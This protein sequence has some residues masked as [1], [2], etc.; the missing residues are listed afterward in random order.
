MIKVRLGQDGRVRF[1][2]LV[3][4]ASEQPCIMRMKVGTKTIEMVAQEQELTVIVH[5]D[6]N[7]CDEWWIGGE[8]NGTAFLVGSPQRRGV[9]CS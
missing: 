7:Q 9:D 1:I 6:P 4:I 8:G 5:P 2:V 3:Q